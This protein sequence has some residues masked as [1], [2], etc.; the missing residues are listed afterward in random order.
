MI[1]GEATRDGTKPRTT[2]TW[3]QADFGLVCRFPS[4]TEC[5]FACV[6]AHISESLTIL[7]RDLGDKMAKMWR[8]AYVNTLNS[9]QTH[10]M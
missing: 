8:D 2:K 5:V 9:R 10:S 4:M 7:V 6:P 1:K 3:L